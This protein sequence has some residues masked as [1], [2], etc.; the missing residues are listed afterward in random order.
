MAVSS[1]RRWCQF[2]HVY[3]WDGAAAASLSLW[4]TSPFGLFLTADAKSHEQRKWFVVR[5]VRKN[6]PDGAA[7]R[8]I[9][10]SY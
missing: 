5:G 7:V 6:V 10:S 1:G 9:V 4:L 3:A 2:S 8:A